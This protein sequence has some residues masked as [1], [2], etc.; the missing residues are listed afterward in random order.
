M[1]ACILNSC[2]IIKAS[3]M[4][5]QAPCPKF[6][7]VACAASPIKSL[8]WSKRNGITCRTFQNRVV[9]GSVF[10]SKEANKIYK[11]NNINKKDGMVNKKPS[12]IL[13]LTTNAIS[14]SRER[15]AEDMLNISGTIKPVNKPTA[16]NNCKKPVNALS[17]TR[18]KCL[19]SA[20]IFF[21]VTA[22]IP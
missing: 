12:L 15:P 1:P 10:S 6:G 17:F 20:S 14:I 3:S 2:A 9:N 7:V 11:F 21:V 22:V 5:W 18:P 19:N 16:P 8:T 4:A 13:I